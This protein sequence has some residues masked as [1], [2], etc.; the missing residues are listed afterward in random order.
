MSRDSRPQRVWRL[1]STTSVTSMPALNNAIPGSIDAHRELAIEYIS[2]QMLTLDPENPR[3]HSTKHIRQ[4][5]RSINELGFNVPVQADAENKVVSGHGR[6]LAARK[7]E[8]P[9]IPVIRLEHLTPTQL[10]AFAIADNKLTE[11]AEWNPFLLGEQLKALS[12]VGLDFSVEVTGFETSEIDLLIEGLEPAGK[13]GA[14]KADKADDLS[15][16]ESTTKIT[17]CGD[18]WLMGPHRVL[19]GDALKHDS[20][21]DLMQGQKAVAALVD[22][23]F[24]VRIDGHAGG[25]GKIQH[26]EFP[27]A[28]GEMSEA[29]FLNFLTRSCTLLAA[30]SVDGSLHYVWIDW[31]HF[32][33]LL[34]A[35]NKVY[36]EFKALCVWNKGTGGM[37]SFY[38][39]QHE[40]ILVFKNGRAP[41]RNNIQLGQFGRYRTNVW[42]YPGLNSFARSTEEGN[43]LALHPTVK[44]AALVSDAILDCTARG[45]IVL[46]S[47]LGSGTT[48]IAAERTGRVCFGIELDPH[49]VDTIV[50]RWQ[51]FTGMSA[52]HAVSG[53]SF[54]E[55]VK[56]VGE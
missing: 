42:N 35:G 17:K 46:D 11:N 55:L 48:V 26:R 45:E 27:M 7:L 6:V 25:L 29:E 9:S 56:E 49:Y 28:S 33:D 39:S 4:I 21:S 40:L 23:P 16:S 24:N 44:P 47:F 5:A 32:G 30:N 19:C 1:S 50:R 36:E 51:R 37:G 34:C 2:P 3:V 20:F 14:D 18:L 13:S 12:E 52:R 8:M 10:R 43:L 38:R 31:R 54:D 15:E 41:H 22:P 53:R